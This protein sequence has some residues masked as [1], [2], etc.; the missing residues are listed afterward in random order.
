[1]YRPHKVVLMRQISCISLPSRP[2]EGFSQHSTH[3][4][5]CDPPLILTP[6]TVEGVAYEED[7]SI[8]GLDVVTWQWKPVQLLLAHKTTHIMIHSSP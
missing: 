7:G 4:I 8:D 1:M 2:V 5:L 6:Y 3:M